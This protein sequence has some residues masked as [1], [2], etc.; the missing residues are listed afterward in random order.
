VLSIHD[1]PSER[2][3]RERT[4]VSDAEAVLLSLRLLQMAETLQRS[5]ALHLYGRYGLSAGRFS[6]LLAIESS[7]KPARPADLAARAGVSRA[8]ITR[9][10]DGLAADGLI[11]RRAD[12]DDGRARRIELTA[13]GRRMVRELT[14]AHAR[15]LGALTRHLTASDRRDL[16]RLL[17]RLRAGLPALSGA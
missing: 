8:T 16:E 1:P 5:Y 11:A 7:S 15:R 14:P 9:L 13:A 6:L 2:E 12:P 4:R 17:D 3:L 10:L